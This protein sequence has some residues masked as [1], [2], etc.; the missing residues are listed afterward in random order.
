MGGKTDFNH[1][2]VIDDLTEAIVLCLFFTDRLGV[3]SDKDSFKF[4][5]LDILQL[6]QP[7]LDV[8]WVTEEGLVFSIRQEC[9]Y[10]D[11]LR[12][13]LDRVHDRG[14]EPFNLPLPT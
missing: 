14:W 8:V 6:R 5:Q 9:F 3:K 12:Q 11:L 13:R 2:L 1:V 4:L 10:L 7:K